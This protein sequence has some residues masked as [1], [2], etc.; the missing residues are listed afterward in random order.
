M[1][2][3]KAGFQTTDRATGL[4]M[5]GRGV[6]KEAL[7]MLDMVSFPLQLGVQLALAHA[8]AGARPLER[9]VLW[10]FPLRAA[11]G[12]LWL[13]V[14]YV[15]L[16]DR[17]ADPW[18]PDGVPWSVLALVF[19]VSN[20]H[21]AVQSVMFM[22]QMAFFSQV[23]RTSPRL[24]GSY[25]TLLNTVTNLGSQASAGEP[26]PSQFFRSSLTF[27]PPNTSPPHP[28][29]VP[30]TPLHPP[31]THS[32]LVRRSGPARCRSGSLMPSR[33]AAS[34]A[35]SLRA[36]QASPTARSGTRSCA[37]A[38]RRCRRSATMPGRFGSGVAGG[39]PA[40]L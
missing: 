34:T 4:V 12:L 26:P 7:A 18:T 31:T 5:Q 1:V 11:F 24:G 2:T 27:P 6:P 29:F 25:M 22:G 15:L 36:W 8:S 39:K 38:S 20:A 16:P 37:A 33:A 35:T 13:L 32:H 40:E 10:A 3:L 23:S 19:A 28:H 17:S 14:V 9:L 30:P 21:G